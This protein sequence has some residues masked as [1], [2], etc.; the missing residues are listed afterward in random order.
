MTVLS[1]PPATPSS[2]WPPEQGR[3]TYDDWLRLPDDGFRYE[4]LNGELFMAPPPTPQ[5]QDAATELI[6]R[7]RM[8]AKEHDLGKVLAAPV[9]VRLPN[10]PVPVQPDILF[11]RKERRSIIG[12][13]YI[14]G[15]PDLV[16]EILSPSNWTYDRKQK[17]QAYSE[18]GVQE[19]WIVD[20]RK[21]IV[22]V[23]VLEG[24][25]YALINQYGSGEAVRSTA[26][27]GFEIKVDDIFAS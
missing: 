4:I 6:S 25:T 24:R 11:V 18:A 20:Y 22:E 16:V 27:K 7:M 12:Q 14:E 13:D 8:F 5:H 15:A 21:K 10:Q 1:A 19:Y 2:T 3:W 9:G 23:F 17:F 26:L